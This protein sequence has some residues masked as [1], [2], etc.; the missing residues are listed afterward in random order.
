MVELLFK[1]NKIVAHSQESVVLKINYLCQDKNE[2]LKLNLTF[3]FKIS[4]VYRFHH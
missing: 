4:L 3:L 1:K 2:K